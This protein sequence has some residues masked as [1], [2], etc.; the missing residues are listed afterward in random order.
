MNNEKY[1]NEKKHN[2]EFLETIIKSA[3]L[4]YLT[5]LKWTPLNWH[6][7]TWIKAES[8][9]WEDW[10]AHAILNSYST[11]NLKYCMI[12][13]AALQ[14]ANEV[15][16]LPIRFHGYFHNEK[17]K[18]PSKIRRAIEIISPQKLNIHDLNHL[19]VHALRHRYSYCQNIFLIFLSQ[20]DYYDFLIKRTQFDKEN[21]LKKTDYCSR[22][23]TYRRIINREHYYQKQNYAEIPQQVHLINGL[24]LLNNRLIEK[25]ICVKNF[26]KTNIKEL[27]DRMTNSDTNVSYMRG[28]FPT[29]TT[30]LVTSED[31]YF[32]PETKEEY[33]TMDLDSVKGS[34]RYDVFDIYSGRRLSPIYVRRGNTYCTHFWSNDVNNVID[35]KQFEIG[36][37]EEL[38]CSKIFVLH[39]PDNF[40][41]PFEK[42]SPIYNILKR[43]HEKNMK[44][45]KYHL[46]ADAEKKIIL[47][48]HLV[49]L[50]NF[51]FFNKKR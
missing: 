37:E 13:Q 32:D 46:T 20:K 44:D 49:F 47:Y 6:P 42:K 14:E 9:I 26:I 2:L 17:K 10:L 24:K 45:G 3:L 35:N 25:K 27:I 29:N 31:E 15:P 28:G 34:N 41:M 51:A 16:T 18:K 48:L 8:L 4:E 50:I 19:E 40:I 1:F 11:E 39:P 23:L 36:K 22:V 33:R 21:D 43:Y 5:P 7:D 38:V 12:C 30:T